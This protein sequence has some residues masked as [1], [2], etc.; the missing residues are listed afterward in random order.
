MSRL[1]CK[2]AAVFRDD[3]EHRPYARAVLWF[4][5]TVL[6][7]HILKSGLLASGPARHL[8]VQ[9][10]YVAGKCWQAG[11]TPYRVESFTQ[12]W[13]SSLPTEPIAP[14][15][16]VYP[17]TIMPIAV[18]LA[19]LSWPVAKHAY[20]AL[21]VLALAV[22]WSSSIL[23]LW[24]AKPMDYTPWRS[25]LVI[26]LSATMSAVPAVMYIAQTGLIA[27]AGVAC[28]VHYLAKNRPLA[29]GIAC[30]VACVK[31]QLTLLPLLVLFLWARPRQRVIGAIPSIIALG[32]GLLLSSP[33][34]L[35]ADYHASVEEHLNM[36][37]N[38]S[39]SYDDL[40]SLVSSIGVPTMSQMIL[41]AAIVFLVSIH[42]LSRPGRALV[43]LSPASDPSLLLLGIQV[44][45]AIALTL[46]FVPLHAY[47]WVIAMPLFALAW[48]NV[49]R[50]LTVLWLLVLFILGRATTLGQ[51]LDTSA[52]S[53]WVSRLPAWIALTALLALAAS[54]WI[55]A[56]RSVERDRSGRLIADTL[57]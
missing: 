4:L 30:L 52:Q 26:G 55:T 54:S 20:D 16:F 13:A 2:F 28:A 57:S 19:S 56:F 23:F 41:A 21:N 50:A 36:A 25:P 12:H 31:P 33:T 32:I 29:T 53:G 5:A 24:H 11:G 38:Q 42:Y 7:L 9:W 22:I 8:D 15:S 27:T 17:P 39:A 10:I 18:G 48:L 37:F 51:L 44:Q 14:T 47:D 46:C 35:L 49:G 3:K 6:V 43:R 40:G 45:L 34:T 1:L